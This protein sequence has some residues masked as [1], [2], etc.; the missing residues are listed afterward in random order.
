[1]DKKT[2]IDILKENNP[3]SMMKFLLSNAKKPK[4]ICPFRFL[5]EKE[6]E[7]FRNGTNNERIDG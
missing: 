4:P 7:D 5:S 1:M 3:E 6:M 2:F